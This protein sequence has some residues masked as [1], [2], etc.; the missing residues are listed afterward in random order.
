[1]Q[2]PSA[3]SICWRSLL[4]T[5]LLAA[6]LVASAPQDAAAQGAYHFNFPEQRTTIVR[7]P[8]ELRQ[9]PLP[10]SSRPPTV[11]DAASDRSPQ[12]RLSLDEAIRTALEN[13][14]VIR[15]LAG[16]T[17]VHSGRTI[18]DVAIAN[19]VVDQETARFNPF[20]TVNNNWDQLKLPSAIPDPGDPS[21][22]LINGFRTDQH[23][24]DAAISKDN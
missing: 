11:A 7:Q 9:Y 12:L 18:Y 15:V 21:N 6:I 20:I 16:E 3:N 2:S 17:A 13:D 5:S 4:F 14:R 19:T 23:R 1:M 24:L 10:V 8:A 22:T